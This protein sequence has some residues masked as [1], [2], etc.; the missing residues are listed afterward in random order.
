MDT[1]VQPAEPR[2]PDHPVAPAGRT[3]RPTLAHRWAALVGVAVLATSALLVVTASSASADPFNCTTVNGGNFAESRCTDGTGEHRVVMVQRHFNPEVGLLA[4]EGPWVPAGTV[5]RAPC[6]YHQVISLTVQTRASSGPGMSPQPDQP[7]MPPPS[8]NCQMASNGVQIIE[9]PSRANAFRFG[10]FLEY[11]YNSARDL[12]RVTPTVLP[13]FIQLPPSVG[14]VSINSAIPALGAVTANDNPV[15][16]SQG[17]VYVG[18]YTVNAT[19]FPN[20]S[21]ARQTYQASV[22]VVINAN[23]AAALP[24]VLI[25]TS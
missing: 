13:P 8:L 23:G 21:A 5:S 9:V 24:P 7:P 2:P 6:G 16:T 4:C 14:T 19:F 12:V 11:C 15:R 20:S 3:G 17:Q 22:S 18:V 25:R 1:Y 10:F